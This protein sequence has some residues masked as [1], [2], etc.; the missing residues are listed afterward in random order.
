MI[1]F[2]SA[3]A[4]DVVCQDPEGQRPVA[5]NDHPVQVSKS[6]LGNGKQDTEVDKGDYLAPYNADP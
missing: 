3:D 6:G 4:R 2:D 5:Q 1:Q